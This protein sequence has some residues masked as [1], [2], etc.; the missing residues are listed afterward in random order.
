MMTGVFEVQNENRGRDF[1]N[2]GVIDYSGHLKVGV[3]RLGIYVGI[4]LH[5]KLLP[6]V[7]IISGLT[8]ALGHTHAQRRCQDGVHGATH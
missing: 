1:I 3:S 7:P 6:L 8:P 5:F 2:I 4:N